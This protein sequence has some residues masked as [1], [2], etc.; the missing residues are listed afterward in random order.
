MVNR[1]GTKKKTHFL[2]DSIKNYR[3]QTRKQNLIVKHHRS[4]I[5]GPFHH[6]HLLDVGLVQRHQAGM[7]PHADRC[8]MKVVEQHRQ[9]VVQAPARV[10][11]ELQRPRRGQ[12]EHVARRL[13]AEPQLQIERKFRPFDG[14][15]QM[16]AVNCFVGNGRKNGSWF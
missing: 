8:Q 13:L 11:V 10:K 16:A 2:R 4:L 14:F 3:Q 6:V 9:M 7:D 5:R 15:L 1:T 12:A